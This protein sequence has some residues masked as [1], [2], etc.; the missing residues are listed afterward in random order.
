MPSLA[1]ITLTS[2]GDARG[3]TSVGP[4]AVRLNIPN[5]AET[6]S[7]QTITTVDTHE[8]LALP[9]NVVALLVPYDHYDL[10][11]SDP[12]GSGTCT[13]LFTGTTALQVRCVNYT[14]GNNNNPTA[15]LGIGYL[16]FMK[17]YPLHHK[18]VGFI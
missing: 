3:V 15:G 8:T 1:K 13:R 4:A 5:N 14:V 2:A 11:G 18:T 10:A 9:S 17:P 12:D 7:A 6:I 16:C